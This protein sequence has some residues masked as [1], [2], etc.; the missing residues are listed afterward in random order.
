MEGIPLSA[1]PLRTFRPSIGIHSYQ[2]V[3]DGY[4]RHE[5]KRDRGAPE[6]YGDP[7]PHDKGVV[8]MDDGLREK[9][10]QVRDIPNGHH[11]AEKAAKEPN[12]L[13]LSRKVELIED[14]AYE[15]RTLQTRRRSLGQCT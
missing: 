8:Q 10:Q 15:D 11:G 1:F 3:V 2:A 14:G 12:G 4:Q 6:S 7:E 13:G 9:K 5:R